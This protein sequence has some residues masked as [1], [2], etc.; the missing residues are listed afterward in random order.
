MLPLWRAKH[1]FIDY[2]TNHIKFSLV[3]CDDHGGF[4]PFLNYGATECFQHSEGALRDS[5]REKR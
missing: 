5:K 1:T 2:M 3:V 4:L